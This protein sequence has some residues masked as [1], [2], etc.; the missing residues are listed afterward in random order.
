MMRIVLVAVAAG[1]LSGCM[2]APIQQAG[3]PI[4]LTPAQITNIEAAV[5]TRLREPASATFLGSPRAARLAN[6]EV[7]VCGAVNSR[8]AFGGMTDWVPY[9]GNLQ[10]DAFIPIRVGGTTSEQEVTIVTCR[11]AGVHG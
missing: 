10:G 11:Q 4:S 6:G 2:S 3:T 8:N 9:I 1:I 5:R 7:A